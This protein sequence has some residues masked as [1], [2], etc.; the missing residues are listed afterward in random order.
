MAKGCNEPPVLKI[1]YRGSLRARKV[2]LVFVEREFSL[3]LVVILPR[4]LQIMTSWGLT[5]EELLYV[6]PLWLLQWSTCN[7]PLNIIGLAFFVKISPGIS[8]TNQEI[9]VEPRIRDHTSWQYPRWGKDLVSWHPPLCAHLQSQIPQ[10]GTTLTHAMNIP[11]G[12]SITGIFTSAGSIPNYLSPP[13]KW[14][15]MAGGCLYLNI[16]DSCRL[17]TCWCQH[18]SI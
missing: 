15:T 4:L 11:L 14:G 10:N 18:W 8:P 9:S 12:K 13:L 2:P 16:Q 1:H 5:W 7:L 17:S 6:Q 3:T